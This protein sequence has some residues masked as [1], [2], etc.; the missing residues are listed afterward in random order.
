MFSFFRRLG[1]PSWVEINATIASF[2]HR[3][4]I[5]FIGLSLL[6]LVSVGGA[7]YL[8]NERI[9]V[10]TANKGGYLIEGVLGTPRYINPLLATSDAD[11]DLTALI[12]SGLLRATGDGKLIPD[13]ASDYSVS[14][15]GLVYTFN[16]KKNLTWHDGEPITIDD[17][18]FTVLRAQDQGLKSSK[19]ANW[20]GVL[21]EKSGAN[22]VKFV[23]KK[24][25]SSFL[26][27]LTMG[28]LPKHIWKNISTENFYL[29]NFNINPIGSGPY[30]VAG[31]KKTAEGIP[32]TYYLTPFSNFALGQALI[33]N[34]QINFYSNSKEL[35]DAYRYNNIESMASVGPESVL[36]VSNSNSQIIKSHLPRIFAVFF[37]QNQAKVF[38]NK[39][40]RQ[41]LNL[42]I[43]RNRI[44]T[45]VLKGY[46]T[47]ISGPIPPGCLGY[48]EQIITTDI[49]KAKEILT[50]AGWRMGKDGVLEK[51][52]ISGSKKK[53]VEKV[54]DRLEFTLI[55]ANTSE[56]KRA[57]DLVAADWSKLGAKVKVSVFEPGDLH[58]NVIRP[59]KFDAILFGEVVSRNT[60]PFPFWHSSQRQDPGLNIAMYA[61]K[62]VDK[63]LEDARTTTDEAKRLINYDKFQNEIASDIPAVFLYS[64][65]FLYILPTKVKG[66]KIPTITTPAERFLSIY[67]WYINHERV[68]KIFAP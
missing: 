12:Y 9:L 55:T 62:K 40:V 1:W 18:I 5:I 13:L 27:N 19:R 59:R 64:P 10:D 58:Q 57:A 8:L 51:V 66:V 32:S 31:V 3:Q 7:I 34:L 25:Y 39:E 67:K 11:R 6:L 41:A 22:Q 45:D 52:V 36:V 30:K 2:S 24:P 17:V 15:N 60:D 48:K 53:P 42:A 43:D 46:G 61:N 21:V 38:A 4:K 49:T 33:S 63:Y 54:T 65:D 44:I 16:L 23:L 28:I 47:A 20:E 35:L 50:K 26:D 68:W 37:N 14:N 56:L 29:S